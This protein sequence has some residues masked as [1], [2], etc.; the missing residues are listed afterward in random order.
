MIK[1]ANIDLKTLGIVP[2]FISGVLDMPQRQG[3][4]TYDWGDE[5]EPLVSASDIYFG[6]REI[7]LDCLFDE[8]LGV[9]FKASSDTLRGIGTIQTLETEYGNYEA[10]LD[11][12]RVVKS[13][14]GGKTIRLKFQELNP[15][16]SGGLPT[17]SGVGSVRID[18]YDFFTHFGL[19]VESTVINEISTLKASKQ[20]TFKTNH[21]SVYR[22]PH[23]LNVKV[24]GIYASKAEMTTKINALNRLLAKPGLRHFVYNGL[25]FQ[26]Y[27]DE[28]FKVKIVRNRVEI[29]LKLKVMALY[30]Y[31]ELVQDVINQIELQARPQS[32]L[33]ETDNT[34]ASFVQGKDTFVAADSAKL[35]GQLP[36]FY[37]KESEVKALRDL[38]LAAELE[39]ATNF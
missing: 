20:T 35:G 29:N 14:K 15:D 37:A 32:D 17:T 34:Q 18:G 33:A 30:T 16:L 3:D 13:Y 23:E 10:K 28:G 31:E 5:I 21:L 24:N 2:R 1:F 6:K 25:G 4:T 12:L 26:T 19:L 8:R 22:N 9:D 27:V 39:T 36:A 11:D 7:L 38:D